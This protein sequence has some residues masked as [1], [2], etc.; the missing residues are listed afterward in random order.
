[1]RSTAVVVAVLASAPCLAQM[2]VKEIQLTR[3]G[4]RY[5][6]QLVLDFRPSEAVLEALDASVPLVFEL[7]QR[8]PNGVSTQAVTLSYAPLFE[9]FELRVGEQITPF[10]LRTELLDAFS[11]LRGVPLRLDALA[12]RMHLQIGKLPAPLRLPALLD[13]DWYLDTGWID[14]RANVEQSK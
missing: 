6:A 8:T 11:S 4:A 7:A 2:D 3:V 13:R 14:L 1:M 9:R 12:L 5:D 10:R